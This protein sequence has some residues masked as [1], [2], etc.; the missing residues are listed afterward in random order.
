MRKNGRVVYSAQEREMDEFIAR[1]APHFL[2]L[3][4]NLDKIIQSLGSDDPARE[5]SSKLGCELDVARQLLSTQLRKLSPAS[6]EAQRLE[7]EA[8]LSRLREG[9]PTGRGQS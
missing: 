1:F 8:A 2:E 6:M 3:P 5:V 7:Y 4:N 9:G